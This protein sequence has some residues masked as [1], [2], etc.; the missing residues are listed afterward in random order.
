[1]FYTIKI[2]FLYQISIL[3]PVG[4]STSIHCMEYEAGHFDKC[5]TT[6]EELWMCSHT[7]TQHSSQVSPSMCPLPPFHGYLKDQ[8]MSLNGCFFKLFAAATLIICLYI[9]LWIYYAY[10]SPCYIFPAK[11]PPNGA[12]T[13]RDEHLPDQ[14]SQFLFFL[15][16]RSSIPN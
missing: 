16:R 7:L 4:R 1:M 9:S 2:M 15:P 11:A 12:E 13:R 10:T 8:H 6:I 5:H 3:L 14:N